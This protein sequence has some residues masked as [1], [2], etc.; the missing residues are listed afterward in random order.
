MKAYDL[1]IPKLALNKKLIKNFSS[2]RSLNISDFLKISE[3]KNFYKRVLSDAVLSELSFGSTI[4]DV[5]SQFI[6]EKLI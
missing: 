1:L 2:Y 4:S 6:F 3:E 5:A